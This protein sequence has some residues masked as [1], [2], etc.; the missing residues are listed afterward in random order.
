[1][2]TGLDNASANLKETKLESPPEE[3][4]EVI[5]AFKWMEFL[6]S[7]VGHSGLEEVLEFYKEMSWIS[8]DVVIF[9]EKLSMGFRSFRGENERKY[10]TKEES[11]LE[12]QNY[13]ST[14]DH[15]KSLLFME[16]LKGNEV[17]KDVVARVDKMVKRLS[18]KANKISGI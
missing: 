11:D 2:M 18:R 12:P 13:L 4:E 8:D 9:L 15:I 16:A 6:V 5:I 1:M 7:K 14:E 3:F 17:D 10:I